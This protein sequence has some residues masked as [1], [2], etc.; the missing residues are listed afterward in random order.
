MG[1]GAPETIQCLAGRLGHNDGGGELFNLKQSETLLAAVCLTFQ[2]TVEG[3][4][5]RSVVGKPENFLE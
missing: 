4:A 2:E 5:N 3:N 1:R